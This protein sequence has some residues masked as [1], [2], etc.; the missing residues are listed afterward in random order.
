MSAVAPLVGDSAPQPRPSRNLIVCCDGT[1]NVWKPGARQTNVVKLVQALVR[2][3][4]RQLHY[5]DPGVGTPDGYVS[6]DPRS[7]GDIV[8]RVA[9]LVWGD[10]VWANVAGAYS[11]LV[12]TYQPG[13]RIYLFGFSRGAF[14]ARAVAGVV[15]LF[16]VLRPEHDNLI[17]TLLETYR[18]KPKSPRVPEASESD[19]NSDTDV[20]KPR[21]REDIG[22]SLRSNFAYTDT[23]TNVHFIGVWDTVETVGLSELA[24]G[25]TLTSDPTVK[26]SFIHV[27]HAL[28]L[29]ERREPYSPRLY[30][31]PS[32][33]QEGH[34]YKQV[35]FAGCHSD[36]GGGYEEEGL[37]NTSFHWMAREAN[38]CGLL[39]EFSLADVH[40][41]NP[42][43]TLHDEVTA[44]PG[45]TLASV[46]NRALPAGSAYHASVA[47]RIANPGCRYRSP[48]PTDAPIV[49]TAPSIVAPDGTTQARPI[50]SIAEPRA[51]LRPQLETRHFIW[52]GVSFVATFILFWWHHPDE[53]AL[54]QAQ[55]RA[56]LSGDFCEALR[57][58]GFPVVRTLDH[59]LLWDTVAVVA[60]ASLL[61]I[62]GLML[63]R[64]SDQDGAVPGWLGRWF[65]WVALTLPMF[66]LLENFLSDRLILHSGHGT[67]L[68][69]DAWISRAASWTL[70]AVSGLKMA[71]IAALGL[72]VLT[73]A[74]RGFRR[75][76]W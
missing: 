52:M 17:P 20:G 29:D 2:D 13:D 8:K 16:G 69:C 61:P 5:Y 57:Q 37:A 33:V 14:T 25:A 71:A 58:Q 30:L 23:D 22:D 51:T 55:L 56:L 68:L 3:P 12:Q 11:F 21:K 35:W 54:A 45:W 24:M 15:N 72:L 66:D 42:C 59:L 74:V 26:P 47:E 48:L 62:L 53:H 75:L 9:G 6:E 32:V 36:V 19:T 43:D 10:G 41:I 44:N 64:L 39:V 27:R 18:T 63:F 50:P 28:A 76:N 4:A 46:G 65:Q 49:H 34:T 70:G 7:P 1:G 67:A 38:H 31:P 60:Y 73:C 40:P